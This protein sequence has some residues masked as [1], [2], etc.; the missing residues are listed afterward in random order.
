MEKFYRVK[1][2]SYPAK[3]DVLFCRDFKQLDLVRKYT[4]VDSGFCC[5]LK[6]PSGL[7]NYH[8]N[9]LIVVFTIECVDSLM[10]L[11]SCYVVL[12]DC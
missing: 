12:C 11:S 7:F 1:L 2:H 8:I 5:M 10:S 6:S 3:I 4:K 9:Q